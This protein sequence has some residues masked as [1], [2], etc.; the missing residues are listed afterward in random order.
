MSLKRILLV[1]LTAIVVFLVSAELLSSLTEPQVQGQISLYQTN[2]VLQ[3]NEWSGF[4]EYPQAKALLGRDPQADARR[5]Y[6]KTIQ[7]LG[8]LPTITA[9]QSQQISQAQLNLGILEAVGAETLA[10]APK[11]WAAAAT[12]PD[13]DRQLAQ[14]LQQ[15]WQTPPIIMP[16]AEI[17]ITTHLTGWFQA[18]ALQRLYQ[19]ENNSAQLSALQ[20]TVQELAQAAV[21]RLALVAVL[22]LAGSVLGI[23]LLVGWGVNQYRQR[24]QVLRHLNLDIPWSSETTLAV[25]VGWFVAFFGISFLIVPLALELIGGRGLVATPFGQAIYALITYSLMVVAGFGILIYTWKQYPKPIFQW[26]SFSGKTRWWAWSIGA[27]FVALPLVLLTSLLSQQL[28]N[29]QGGGNPLLEVILASHDYR[30]FAI[31]WLMVAVM[32]PVFEETLFRGFLLPSLLP[33]MRPVTAM[34][35]SGGLF[36][37][38][39]LNAADLLPLAVLGTILGY[40]YWRSGNLLASMLLHGIWNS[41]SFIGLLLL[42]P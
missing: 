38:A 26:L 23:F 22:P 27:Y 5:A 1:A 12:G 11:T 3:A 34:L 39:H 33:R 4:Q 9:Q 17:L 14:T 41:G 8:E 30:S 19:V 10:A 21:I 32:A 2:L 15:L 28:L 42:S 6:Q 13:S 36:A 35:T 40:V 37:I 7:S 24:E 16:Q 31:L 20:Q 25:M 29:N 18:Q